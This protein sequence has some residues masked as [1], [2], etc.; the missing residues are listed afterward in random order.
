MNLELSEK[1]RQYII[2]LLRIRIQCR[3]IKDDVAAELNEIYRRMTGYDHMRIAA[4]K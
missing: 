2:Y 4:K 3:Y 1:E